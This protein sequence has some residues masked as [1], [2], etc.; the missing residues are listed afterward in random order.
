MKI[1]KKI[2]LDALSVYDDS[3]IKTK[4]RTYCDEVYTNFCSLTFPEDGESFTVIYIDY[5]LVYENKYYLQMHLDNCAY[6]TVDK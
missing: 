3:Y 5:S 4:I 2:E 1:L 6:K